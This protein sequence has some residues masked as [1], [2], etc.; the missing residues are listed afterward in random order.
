MTPIESRLVLEFEAGQTSFR[1]IRQNATYAQLF[2]LV[3][4]INLFQDTPVQKILLVTT[5]HF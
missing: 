3:Q 2:Q 4:S 5:T 1:H